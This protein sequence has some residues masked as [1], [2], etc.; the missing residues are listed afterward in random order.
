MLEQKPG[1]IGP[2]NNG[3]SKNLIIQ[4]SILLSGYKKITHT[5]GFGDLKNDGDLTDVTLACEN[6]KQIEAQKVVLA[7]ISLFF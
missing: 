6:G 4:S 1:P 3:H 7:G 5:S 2:T